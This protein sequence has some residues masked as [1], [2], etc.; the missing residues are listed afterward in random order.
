MAEAVRNVLKDS[1]TEEGSGLRRKSQLGE[2]WK[3]LKKNKPAVI[4]MAVILILILVAIFADVLAPYPPDQ[5][6]MPSRLQYPSAKHVMGTD[7]FGRDL[8]SRMIYGARTSLLVATLAVS[9]SLFFG[10][11]SGY[12]AAFFGGR[13]EMVV[14]RIMDTFLSI[15]STIL[16]IS[17]AVSLGF[18]VA[19]TAVAIGISNFPVFAR[20]ARASVLTVKDNEFIEAARS[21]GASNLR[22]LLRHIVPNSLAPILVQISLSIAN[23]ILVI[24]SLSFLGCGIQ[25][26]TAEWGSIL[27]VGREYIRDFYPFVLFP[28]IMISVTL[29]C[30][31]LF[32]D[33]LRDAL[34]P[35]LKQ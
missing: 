17:I 12:S 16:A 9:I 7:N 31:N 19:S 28:G 15:P 13:Y 32:S 35:R 29:I 26:P 20:V 4:G 30:F 11:I 34:D 18:G 6:D 22:I 1:L 27:S 10:C 23:A 14:M 8:F 5:I 24:S 2:I 3:R 21:I 33:G 25:A